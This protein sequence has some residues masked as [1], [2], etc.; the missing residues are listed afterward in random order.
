MLVVGLKRR[1]THI[2]KQQFP[3]R[4]GFKITTTAWCST[5]AVYPCMTKSASIQF[6]N[7]RH[8]ER[9]RDREIQ[10]M[11]SSTDSELVGYRPGNRVHSKLQPSP[12]DKDQMV[13]GKRETGQCDGWDE[14]KD[15][16]PGKGLHYV[17]NMPSRPSIWKTM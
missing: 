4:Y 5:R 6:R 16:H 7:G 14:S 3:S 17:F 15:K 13:C 8:Q 9:R 2:N 1:Q 10:G 12:Y 11:P